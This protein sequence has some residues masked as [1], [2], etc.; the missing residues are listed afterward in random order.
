[1]QYD[2]MTSNDCSPRFKIK[3]LTPRNEKEFGNTPNLDLTPNQ[4]AKFSRD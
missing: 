1:M 3:E 4:L 2:S